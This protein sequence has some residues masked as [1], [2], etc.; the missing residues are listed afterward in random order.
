MTISASLT[1]YYLN[2]RQAVTAG[3][4]AAIRQGEHPGKNELS[5]LSR[6]FTVAGFDLQL[7]IDTLEFKGMDEGFKAF[8][9]TIGYEGKSLDELSKEE[10]EALVSDNGFFGIEQTAKRISDFVLLGAG[11]NEELLRAGRQG[12]LKGFEEAEKL[13]GEKLPEISYKTI[14]KALETIDTAMH[15]YGYAIIDA[16]A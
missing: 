2:V 11:D 5:K 8:L 7:Q 15:D 13:W 10:A 4:T 16:E 6:E 9:D 1:S 14:G 3:D 12:V